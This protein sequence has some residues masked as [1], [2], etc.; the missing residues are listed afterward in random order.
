MRMRQIKC[1]CKNT[2][3]GGILSV[4]RDHK[5]NHRDVIFE[6]V[7]EGGV[8]FLYEVVEGKCIP[9]GI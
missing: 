7:L 2:K 8:G 5:K 6:L 9:V 3:E 4:Q 1:C